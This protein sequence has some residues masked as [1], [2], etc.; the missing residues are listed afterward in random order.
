MKS[1]RSGRS[2]RSGKSGKGGG[3]SNGGMSRGAKGKSRGQ[4]HK[5]PLSGANSGKLSQD[6]GFKIGSDRDGGEG[7]E[8]CL[9][10]T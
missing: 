4:R 1:G 9:R 7:D 6:L 8:V 5:R 2:G 3:K 10:N